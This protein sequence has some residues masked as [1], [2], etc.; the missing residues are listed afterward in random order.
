MLRSATRELR[1]GWHLS[2]NVTTQTKYASRLK[3]A[4]A[5]RYVSSVDALEAA[6]VNGRRADDYQK[7]PKKVLPKRLYDPKNVF[8]F[9]DFNEDN[10]HGRI[11]RRLRMLKGWV[12]QSPAVLLRKY[13][14][15]EQ[16]SRETLLEIAAIRTV[17]LPVVVIQMHLRHQVEAD[18]ENNRDLAQALPNKSEW[19]ALMKTLEYSGNTEERLNEY[20]SIL[21]AKTDEDRC[22]LFLADMSPK[23][24]FMLNYLLRLGSSISKI[25]TL[26]HLL[27]YVQ[28]RLRATTEKARKMSWG[29]GRA[30]SEM[31]RFTTEDFMII[32]E[33]LAFHCR[34]IEARRLIVL[35]DIMAEFIFNYKIG[36][37][38]QTYWMRC[39]Y[40]NAGLTAIARNSG[41]GPQ[42]SSVPYAYVWEAQRTLLRMS[43][44]L[45][46]ALLVDRNAFRAIRTVLSGMPKNRDEIHNATRY[47]KS[48][49]PYLRPADGMDEAME[50]EESWSRVVRAGMMMQEAG[51]SKQETDSA[52][53]TLL[54]LTPSGT[55]AI[56]QQVKVDPKQDLSAW[57]ASIIATRNAHEAWKQFCQPPKAGMAP[58]LP[59]YA[60]MFR[61][62][63]ARDADPEK[64]TLPGDNSLSHPTNEDMNLTELEKLRQQPPTPQELYEMMKCE[65]LLPD[66][67]ILHILVANAQ[68]LQEAHRYLRDGS[69]EHQNYAHLLVP[70]PT[71]DMLKAIPLP[72][73]S[74]YVDMLS[75]TVHPKGSNLIRAIRLAELRVGR[76][77]QNWLPHVWAPIMKNVGQHHYGLKL[78][79]EAQL[80]LII[81]L[82]DRI[83]AVQ[84]M[85]LFL[86]NRFVRTLRKILR[87]ELQV[88]ASA[89]EANNTNFN[90]LGAL[91][92]RNAEEDGANT[93][94]DTETRSNSAL[95]L[96]RVLISRMKGFYHALV[97]EEQERQRPEAE[98]TTDLS[99]VDIMRS[100]RDPVLAPFAHDLM[101][102][103]AFAGEYN[104]MAQL[105]MWLMMEWGPLQSQE[106]EMIN[107]EVLPHDVDMLETL[108]AYR[109][110]AEPMLTDEV[111]NHVRDVR[112]QIGIWQWPGDQMVQSYI[113]ANA[114]HG[115]EELTRVLKWARIREHNRQNHLLTNVDDLDLDAIENK[116]ETAEHQFSTHEESRKRTA[117]RSG[118]QGSLLET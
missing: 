82:V 19:E 59:E 104:E 81:H 41:S 26:D 20:M 5:R 97:A 100:R 85:T 84:G 16:P 50:A 9:S 30:S 23:P 47:S 29:R 45:P 28:E 94:M 93:V 43:G 72:L 75:K 33:R 37:A 27:E 55:P 92:C 15:L 63:F 114:V 115:H 44:S 62:S 108:C 24:V 40:F 32:M 89:V 69:T 46:E 66:E 68:T 48:W 71:A 107:M 86:F 101:Q 22:R 103:L 10:G 67:H 117:L 80:R 95:H 64:G 8:K 53:D 112:F 76:R 98:Q 96:F 73:F 87:R 38:E 99:F 51:F 21:F 78:T 77:N 116:H 90:L 113:Q 34:R 31:E 7:R 74:A 49:P 118:E 3:S 58:G 14:A 111:R 105:T 60:A 52:L 110:F 61:R 102:S 65:G 70:D 1:R 12:E 6:I 35:A 109:A 42:H 91:Y 2:R 25:S 57:Q 17:R 79:L 106:D 18:P 11:E 4:Q 88:L 36:S 56:Q 54:G 39:K 13:L 83:D